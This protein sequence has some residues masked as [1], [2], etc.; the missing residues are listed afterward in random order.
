MAKRLLREAAS[1]EFVRRIGWAWRCGG[2]VEWLGGTAAPEAFL[3]RLCVQ[4][5]A[6]RATGVK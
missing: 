4:E 1:E 3:Q 2:L 5:A 6:R